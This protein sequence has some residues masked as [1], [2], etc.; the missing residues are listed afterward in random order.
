MNNQINQINPKKNPFFIIV[1]FIGIFAISAVGFASWKYFGEVSEL[2]RKEFEPVNLSLENEQIKQE[3]ETVNEIF[4]KIKKCKA[5]QNIAKKNQCWID[6]AKE[7]KD[8]NYCKKIS[9]DFPEIRGD[10]YTELAILKD[11]SLICEKVTTASLHESCLEYFE[12]KDGKDETADWKTYQ[13]TK[14][15]FEIKYPKGAIVS[16]INDLSSGLTIARTFGEKLLDE[17]LIEKKPDNISDYFGYF[18]EILIIENPKKL[19]IE[20]WYSEFYAKRKKEAEEKA[21]DMG[22]D[23]ESFPF[24]F[25]PKGK[26]VSIGNYSAYEISIFTGDAMDVYLLIP[27]NGYIYEIYYSN[28]IANDPNWKKHKIKIDQI[29]STFKFTN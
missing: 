2:K 6:L 5:I 15:G 19:T 23:F 16:K 21:K 8:E 1:I 20:K 27:Y 7:E 12:G 9:A 17:T 24:A 4:Q 22:V 3:S 10:C 28:E 29:L 26:Y 14:Y 25:P 18:V 11:D 13:N